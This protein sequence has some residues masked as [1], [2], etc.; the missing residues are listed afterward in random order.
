LNLRAGITGYIFA[1]AIE[2]KLILVKKGVLKLFFTIA[3]TNLKY[4][5]LINQETHN[6]MKKWTIQL[7]LLLGMAIAIFATSRYM[8]NCTPIGLSKKEAQYNTLDKVQSA[9]NLRGIGRHL[10][11]FHK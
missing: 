7:T 11:D 1:S 9:V 6:A 4:I 10:L 8:V 5:R 2:G 3:V